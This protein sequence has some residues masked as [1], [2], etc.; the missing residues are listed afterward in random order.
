MKEPNFKVKEEK[1][2]E[3]FGEF[4][5]EPLETG[6][7]HTLGNALRRVLL[8]SIPGAAVTSVKISGVKHK[9]S[10]VAGLKE[11]VVDLLLNIKE[12]NIKLDSKQSAII[13]LSAKG[14][15]E[16]TAADIELTDGVEISNP[17]HYLGS[18]TDKKSK[19]E[20]E[21]T[22]EKGF[23]YSLAE[24]VKS[25][26][27]GVI[28]TD[29]IF[30]PI[31]RVTY[32]VEATRVG[33]QTNF[34]KLVLKIWTNGAISPKAALEDASRLLAG[35]FTQ[36]YVSDASAGQAVEV[37]G[38]SL[39]SSIPEEILKLTI[40]EIDLPTR[41]YN[42]LRN[43]GIE[44]LGQLLSTPK[45]DLMNMRNMGGKSLGIIEEKLREKGVTFVI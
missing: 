18:L 24:D 21:F 6:F 9:F 14:P 40:D 23:G 4:V 30:T 34:D 38:V 39:V 33:R 3:S 45:K 32:E 8:S 11:N 13:R 5:I 37:G 25:Q 22:V 15:K 19:L 26:T 17:D 35:Y 44:T 36:I 16:V 42:S 29:A 2:E 27:L 20:I 43:G 28:P 1:I 31:K 41:I 10:A 12:L 7:G